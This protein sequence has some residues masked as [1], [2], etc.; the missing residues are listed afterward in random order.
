MSAKSWQNINQKLIATA[1]NYN[2]QWHNGQQRDKQHYEAIMT[3]IAMAG[4]NT[5]D[6]VLQL[7]MDNALQIAMV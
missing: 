4:N 3:S 5:T 1:S 7:A 6:I 2:G